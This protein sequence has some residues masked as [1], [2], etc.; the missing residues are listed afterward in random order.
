[1]S[2]SVRLWYVSIGRLNFE[3][4]ILAICTTLE[5]ARELCDKY[6]ESHSTNGIPDDRIGA[7]IE[8]IMSDYLYEGGF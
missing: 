5:K 2:E 4:K 1:M 7:T 6:N 3:E 8:S